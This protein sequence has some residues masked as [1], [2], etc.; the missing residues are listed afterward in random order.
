MARYPNINDQLANLSVEDQE[1]E[2]LVF[3]GYIEEEVKKYEMCLVGQFLT[4]KN[5]NS[6]AIKSK[7]ADIWKPTMGVN[8]KELEVGIFLFQFY[9]RKDKMWVMNGGPWSFD[10]AM[11]LIDSI[12]EGEEP[13]KVPFWWLNIWIQIHDLPSGFMLEAV[14]QQ[15]GNFFGEFI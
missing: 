5:I 12:S 15:L 4:E 13:L 3:E 8:I 11:L 9:H 6:R 1:N 14:G 7:I 10:N 2:D